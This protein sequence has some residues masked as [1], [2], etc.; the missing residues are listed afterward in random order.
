MNSGWHSM[1][2]AQG[3][4]GQGEY[5]ARLVA[6][7]KLALSPHWWD[8]WNTFTSKY[9]IIQTSLANM[10]FSYFSDTGLIHQSPVKSEKVPILVAVRFGVNLVHWHIKLYIKLCLVQGFVA[11]R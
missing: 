3:A 9:V 2:R 7:K 1:G 11:V 8:S 6:K 5:Q 10:G 4:E